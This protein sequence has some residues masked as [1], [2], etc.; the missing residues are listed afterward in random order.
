M[1]QYYPSLFNLSFVQR[2]NKVFPV[3][4][5][6]KVNIRSKLNV[7]IFGHAQIIEFWSY[8]TYLM[9]E[10]LKKKSGRRSRRCGRPKP[11]KFSFCL[12]D[13]SQ[14]IVKRALKIRTNVFS[15]RNKK[16]ISPQGDYPH[17]VIRLK[18][19]RFRRALAVRHMCIMQ[20]TT[21]RS[22]Q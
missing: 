15:I 11:E 4:N 9:G 21:C 18:V 5:T 13:S 16:W 1:E 20:K 8:M 10:Y 22:L 14:S 2:F 7:P 3:L 6:N 17:S 12:L 19:N